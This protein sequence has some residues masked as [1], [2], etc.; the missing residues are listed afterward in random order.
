MNRSVFLNLLVITVA[1]AV[2]A[3]VAVPAQES[4]GRYGDPRDP[5]VLERLLEEANADFLL[6]DVRT[7]AEYSQGHIPGSMQIDYR[8]IA[9]AMAEVD[10]TQPVV[11]YCRTGNRSAH[12]ERTLRTMGFT[13]V[14]DF[15]GINR[16]RG[17][18]Q[19]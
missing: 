12:A 1:I 2:A 19:R 16:W 11:V 3:V 5:A 17:E 8:V 4:L 18:L 9:D 13:E 10:R 14:Y 15:G 7:D 6:I